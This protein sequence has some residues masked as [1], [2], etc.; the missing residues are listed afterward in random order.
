VDF[1][2]L[3]GVVDADVDV[4]QGGGTRGVG[5]RGALPLLVLESRRVLVTNGR[6]S[7][8]AAATVVDVLSTT[9]LPTPPR[10]RRFTLCLAIAIAIPGTDL[11][12]LEEDR[13]IPL[14]AVRGSIVIIVII[15]MWYY[16]NALL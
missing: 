5:G 11:E 3:N 1:C 14:W 8:T 15:I 10:T 7:I 9:F 6:R 4:V 2:A 13:I 12:I 16:G